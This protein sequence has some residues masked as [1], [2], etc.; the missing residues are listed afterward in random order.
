[1]RDTSRSENFIKISI[2]V[3]FVASHTTGGLLWVLSCFLDKRVVLSSFL[4]YMR[5]AANSS[6]SPYIKLEVPIKSA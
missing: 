2:S 1:M 6:T 3:S 4:A 5:K